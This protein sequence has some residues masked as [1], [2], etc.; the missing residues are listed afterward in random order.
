MLNPDNNAKLEIY[1]LYIKNLNE[2][3]TS[4]YKSKEIF[5]IENIKDYSRSVMK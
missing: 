2:N 5:P 3:L 4:F 1:D